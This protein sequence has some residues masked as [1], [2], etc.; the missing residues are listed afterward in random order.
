[1]AV[2]GSEAVWIRGSMDPRPHRNRGNTDLR[3]S[4]MR[5][6]GS[7]AVACGQSLRSGDATSQDLRPALPDPAGR[8]WSLGSGNVRI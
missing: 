2:D 5:Q 4:Y 7:E 6:Y 1:M 3:W 8:L